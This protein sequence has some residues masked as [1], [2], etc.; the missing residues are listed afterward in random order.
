MPNDIDSK[1][2]GAKSA[3]A[4]AERKFPSPK[5]LVAPAAKIAMPAPAPKTAGESL[6]AELGAK[7]E[8]VKEYIKAMPKMHKGGV[9]KKDGPAILKKGEVV[10]TAEQEKAMEDKKKN[11]PKEPKKA[12]ELM[13]GKKSAKDGEKSDKKDAKSEAKDGKKGGKHKHTHVEHLDDGSHV[14]RHIPR[15]GGDEVSYSS[16]DMA[17]LHSGLDA[18][19]GGNEESAEEQISPGIH[20][21]VAAMAPSAKA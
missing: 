15:G 16:P 17:G 19:L 6:A 8:N 21:K 18:N 7:Q 20:E 3:L 1:V 11:T 5:I 2:A 13:G 9:V 4:G 10:R 12:A 14:V